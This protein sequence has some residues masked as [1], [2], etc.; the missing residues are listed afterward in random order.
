MEVA[1]TWNPVTYIMEAA[2][3]LVLEGF[4]GAAL[5]KGF[6]VI[7]GAGLVM[8]ALNVRMINKYD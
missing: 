5:A 7:V 4:N 1:A 2:R 6:A 3:S 8:L